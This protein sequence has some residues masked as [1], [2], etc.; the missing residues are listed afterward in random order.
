M[1]VGM[2]CAT[3]AGHAPSGTTV[4]KHASQNNDASVS[5]N[6]GTEGIRDRGRSALP[7]CPEF[8]EMRGRRWMCRSSRACPNLLD[9][10]LGSI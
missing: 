5:H 2:G 9:I 10:S 3:V 7:A 8:P 6:A 1:P 4:P